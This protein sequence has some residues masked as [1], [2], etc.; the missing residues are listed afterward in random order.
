M[1]LTIAIFCVL[2]SALTAQHYS[3]WSM[4]VN[5]GAAVNSVDNDQHPAISPDDLALYFVSDRPGGAGGTDIWMTRRSAVDA[6]WQTPVP[7][8][9][10][11]NTSAAEFA[12][13]FG[14]SGHLLL[15]GSERSG[16]CG[17]RDIWMSFRKHKGDDFGWEPPVNLGCVLNFSGF[18][19]GPTWF[20]DDNGVVTVYFTSQNRPGGLGD[21]DV[22]ASTMNADGTFTSPYNV[23]EVNSQFRDT[24]TAIRR[25]GLELFFTS[26]RPGSV[27]GSLDLWVATRGTT[28]GAWSTPTN[29]GAPINGTFNDGAPALSHD[30][31]TLYFYSNRLGGIG[32]NDL[33]VSTRTKVAPGKSKR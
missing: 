12:P 1:L 32:A 5:L 28:S 4:P 21:F 3:A 30:A 22:W 11:I 33:Y 6:P 10:T 7:L 14:A 17:S 18:D 8:P 23:A 26:N 15:F 16:G 31:T 9:T 19:D 24:R 13:T 25:D 20:E 27:A 2:V 29:V